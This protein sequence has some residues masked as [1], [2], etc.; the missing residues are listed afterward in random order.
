MSFA[1]GRMLRTGVAVCSMV[2]LGTVVAVYYGF[3]LGT[4]AVYYGFRLG[5]V[6]IKD[7]FSSGRG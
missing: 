6:A 7:G 3:R 4:M 1:W 2:R 5:A